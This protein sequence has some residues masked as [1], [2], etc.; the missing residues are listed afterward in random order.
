MN[1]ISNLCNYL[2]TVYCLIFL[3]SLQVNLNKELQ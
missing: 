1:N 3:R 2:T